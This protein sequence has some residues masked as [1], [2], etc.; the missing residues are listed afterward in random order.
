MRHAITILAASAALSASLVAGLAAADVARAPAAPKP[1][2]SAWI[3]PPAKADPACR[4]A[5][6]P[7][8]SAGCGERKVR[9]IGTGGPQ[10][11]APALLGLP[12]G[13]APVFVSLPPR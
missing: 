9:V 10:A 8:R 4:E 13:A 6:W 7:Y 11:A 3:D 5:A 2:A 1:Q 12:N